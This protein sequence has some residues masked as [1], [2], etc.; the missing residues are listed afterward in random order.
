ME[1]G[2]ET[3]DVQEQRFVAAS[4][5]PFENVRAVKNS[6][7]QKKLSLSEWDI[8]KIDDG[9]EARRR[10][11]EKYFWATFQ[12][13][14][15][16]MEQ[17]DVELS[18]NGETLTFQRGKKTIVPQKFLECA[19][20]TTYVKFI[21]IPGQARKR[22]DTVCTFPYTRHEETT[23]KEFKNLKAAGDKRTKELIRKYG[24]DFNPD[25]FEGDDNV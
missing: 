5:L 19:D 9:Y 10:V 22:G 6:I 15:S 1:E 7:A 2:Q 18:V 20:H 4:G 16:Q 21:Q 11:Q 8:V 23:E 17:I 25:D 24:H 3:V 12:Q 14:M 13:R